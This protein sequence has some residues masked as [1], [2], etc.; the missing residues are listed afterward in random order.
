M[1]LTHLAANQAE[2]HSADVKL[3]LELPVERQALAQGARALIN[4]DGRSHGRHL[5]R[6]LRLPVNRKQKTSKRGLIHH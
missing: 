3:D 6:L 5:L 1:N 4:H 2:N